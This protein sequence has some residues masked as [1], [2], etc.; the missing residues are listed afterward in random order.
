MEALSILRFRCDLGRSRSS[1]CFNLRT[2]ATRPCIGTRV[3][4]SL[5]WA[6]SSILGI[7]GLVGRKFGWLVV[8]KCKCAEEWFRRMDQCCTA[9]SPLARA[10]ESRSWKPTWLKKHHCHHHYNIPSVW[11]NHPDDHLWPH[12]IHDHYLVPERTGQAAWR[13][14]SSPSPLRKRLYLKDLRSFWTGT[15]WK[16]HRQSWLEQKLD[17]N[18]PR[19][20]Y[21]TRKRQFPS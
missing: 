9:D 13:V 16:I 17:L 20:Q 7:K 14:S 19:S 21:D 5:K 18:E 10:R 15:F 1:I 6:H 2:L 3:S 8:G 12:L 11:S 4:L